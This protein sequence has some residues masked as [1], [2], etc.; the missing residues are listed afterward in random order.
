MSKAKA[1]GCIIMAAAL[2]GLIGFFVKH[3]SAQGFTPLQITCLRT[4]AASICITP[5]VAMQGMDKFKIDLKY[6]NLLV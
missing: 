2:W 6:F 4:I 3:L 5:L 1:Y